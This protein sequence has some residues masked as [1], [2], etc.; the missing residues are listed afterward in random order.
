MKKYTVEVSKTAEQ[1]LCNIISYLRYTLA[2][3]IVA[4]KYKTLFKQA[5]KD[6]KNV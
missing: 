5:L 2:S 1:D 4:D 6:S 3:N